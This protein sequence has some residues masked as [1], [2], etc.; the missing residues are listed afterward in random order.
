MVHWKLQLLKSD[1]DKSD[2]YKLK[3]VKVVKKVVK[4]AFYNQLSGKEVKIPSTNGLVNK[5]QYD[6][7]KQHIEKKIFIQHLIAN[8]IQGT[9]GVVK[10]IEAIE[11]ENQIPNTTELLSKINFNTKVKEVENK[12]LNRF[13]IKEKLR[14]RNIYCCKICSN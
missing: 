4:K 7:D 1:V 5:S 14:C 3:S 11:I 12:E 8:Q 9:S 10:E 13:C 2:A 6:I